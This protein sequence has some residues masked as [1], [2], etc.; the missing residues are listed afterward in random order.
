MKAGWICGALSLAWLCSCSDS[1]MVE[2]PSTETSGLAARL[3]DS[4]GTP[5][6]GIEVRVVAVGEAWRSRVSDD[7]TTVL[8]VGSTDPSGLVRFELPDPR[9]VALEFAARGFAGRLEAV[10]G[11]DTVRDVLATRAFRL[12]VVAKVPRETV[13]DLFLAGTGFR[14][15][16]LSDSSW[17]FA[18]VPGGS[19]SIV[20]RT[21]SGLAVLGRV[22][23]HGRDLDTTLSSD[24]DSV[25]LDD[26]AV[27]SSRNRYGD[28]LGGGWWYT[29]TD[30]TVG[31]A[32]AIRPGNVLDALVPCALGNCLAFDFI[33]DPDRTHRWSLVG[34]DLD[35]GNLAPQAP[36]ADL[37]RVPI[38]RF[39]AAGTG[40]FWFQLGV[41]TDRG[42]T[43]ACHT[44][45]VAPSELSP[46]D[47]SV[48]SLVCDSVGADL[49]TTY[50]LTWVALGDNHLELGKVRL[51]GA[52]PRSVFPR[53]RR[54]DR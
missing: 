4:A 8:A 14:A 22:V 51:I 47:I 26:F 42:T 53:L 54:P 31:G 20:A 45:F 24:L 50:S 23:L 28:L 9:P 16:R 7:L 32:S 35:G 34:V 39:D 21:D 19:H 41:R 3:I 11:S 29:T 37:S 46:I 5:L 44:L 25:L 40:S 12:G 1:R 30:A 2:G 52:G 27:P 48:S 6:A 36:L 43:T 17:S 15:D 49:R 38:V 10:P 18:S 33:L 13:L